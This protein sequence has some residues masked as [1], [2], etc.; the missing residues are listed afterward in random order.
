MALSDSELIVACRRGD[1]T[2]WETLVLRYQRLIYTI[3]VRAGLDEEVA[4]EVFQHVFVTLH[5][6]LAKIEN[7]ERI[8]AWLVTT[9]R[10]ETLRL[11]PKHLA[12]QAHVSTDD[13]TIEDVPDALPL[14]SE[15]VQALEE[16]QM[17]RIALE[18]LEE[19]CRY[20]LTMLFYHEPPPP[21]AELAAALGTTAGSIGPSRARCLEKLRTRLA[22]SGF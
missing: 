11:L 20:L 4:A 17:V 22:Q 8:R 19:P 1:P 5:Q 15:V 6:Q 21:Y 9:A 3:P 2:A 16:Q 18:Q 14:P 7:P 13:A 10:R 12:S